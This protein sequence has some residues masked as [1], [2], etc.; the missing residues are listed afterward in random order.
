MPA[1]SVAQW[2]WLHTGVE[3]QHHS[4]VTK[5][6]NVGNTMVMNS[7]GTAPPTSSKGKHTHIARRTM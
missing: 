7:N 2:F 3:M 5:L 4:I 6:Q 1:C